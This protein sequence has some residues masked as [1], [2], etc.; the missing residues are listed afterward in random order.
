MLSILLAVIAPAFI[1]ISCTVWLS[2]VLYKYIRSGTYKDDVCTEW[3]NSKQ[4]WR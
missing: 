2:T 4:S 3:N 1:S